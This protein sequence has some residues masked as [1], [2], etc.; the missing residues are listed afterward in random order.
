MT[1]S[2]HDQDDRSS[3]DPEK[4]LRGALDAAPIGLLVVD[5]GGTIRAA[6]AQAHQMF[7]YDGNG[8]I[9]RPIDDLVPERLHAVH[10]SFRA[11]Y[12]AAPRARAMGRGQELRARRADGSELLV[13]IGLSPLAGGEEGM[14]AC[15]VL[16]VTIRVLAEDAL[17]GERE[18]QRMIVDHIADGIVSIDDSGV[19]SAFNRAAERIFG[20][21]A[22]DVIGRHV[23][24]LM[25]EPLRRLSP[26]ALKRIL[27]E[28]VGTAPERQMEVIGQRQDGS[29]VLLNLRISRL[30]DDAGTTITGIVRDVSE[31]RQQEAAVASIQQEKARVE[32]ELQ[33]TEGK[34]RDLIDRANV[35]PYTWDLVQQRFLSIGPR[36][37]ALLGYDES[38]WLSSG[39]WER[40]TF[41]DDWSSVFKS[42]DPHAPLQ[43]EHETQYRMA[44]REGRTVWVRDVLA[45]E[46]VGQGQHIIRGFLFDVTETRQRD[47]QLAHAQKMDAVGQLTGGIAHDFNNLLAVVIGNLDMLAESADLSPRAHEHVQLSLAAACA[48]QN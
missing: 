14:V 22:Y 7:G 30:N 12:L 9:H 11:E 47:M 4:W 28:R 29:A 18:H 44:H 38:E 3:F 33:A 15:T 16:D 20:Y 8:L 6:N 26:R 23:T 13:E 42:M 1:T 40:I 21:Q 17:R 45:N 46:Q 32:S 31:R 36:A 35:V 37:R 24:T 2:S 19:V 27:T 39:F 25:A 10:H 43:G 5:R 41:A 48:A 34:F